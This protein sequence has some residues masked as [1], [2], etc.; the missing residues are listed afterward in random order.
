METKVVTKVC[1]CDA[2]G[3]G[4]AAESSTRLKKKIG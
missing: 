1:V 3:G 4:Q 2:G